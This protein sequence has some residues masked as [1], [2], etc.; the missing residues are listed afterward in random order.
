MS[1]A[2]REVLHEAFFDPVVNTSTSAVGADGSLGALKPTDF[3]VTGYSGFRRVTSTTTMK[4]LYWENNKVRMEFAGRAPQMELSIGFMDVIG[5]DGKVS[6][7]LD[8][9]KSSLSSDGKSL[10]WDASK[11]PWKA[12]DKLM[13]RI[14][15]GMA[16]I[17]GESKEPGTGSGR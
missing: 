13:L 10:S 5:L 3:R 17:G 6:L 12:G 15:E 4:G 8:F 1:V 2:P 14:R 9:N 16:G 11:Q 7:T